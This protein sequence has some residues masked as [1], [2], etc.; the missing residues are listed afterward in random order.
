MSERSGPV[1]VLLRGINVGGHGRLPMDE[2]TRILQELGLEDIAT[3]IQ[4]GN[5]VGRMVGAPS[6]TLGED[7]ASAVQERRGFRPQVL[8]L[9]VDRLHE[10]IDA[11]PFPE[12][13][14]DPKSLHLWFLA[15][16][17]SSPDME[18]L[19]RVAS[20]SER[21]RLAGDVFYL[22][23]PDGVGRSKLAASVEKFLGVAATA[24]NWRTV[25]KLREMAEAVP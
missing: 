3:Y 2:L 12:A 1:I 13:A 21:F 19:A 23:A 6:P 9:A 4:S 7:I 17:P 8:V 25:Q 22:H 24:R 16:E 20:A 11:N 14:A 10:A 5:A 15:E 18:S